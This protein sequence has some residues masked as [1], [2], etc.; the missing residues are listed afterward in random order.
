MQTAIPDD[1]IEA[2]RRAVFRVPSLGVDLRVGERC[3]A[4]AGWT[5][6]FAFITA[7]NPYSEIVSGERN[8][9]AT[10]SLEEALQA[11][12]PGQVL[13]AEGR[14][15]AGEWPPEPGFVVGS[16]TLAQASE[17]GRRFRQNAI[18]WADAD[19]VPRLVLLR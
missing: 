3:Q 8:A 11:L 12:P 16:I 1:L 10:Y 17:L 6:G 18:L 5:G 7:C 2:Y 15:P 13:A 14:D 9:A 4:L 19:A